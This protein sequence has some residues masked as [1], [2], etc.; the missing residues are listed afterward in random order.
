MKKKI[1]LYILSFFFITFLIPVKSFTKSTSIYKNIHPKYIFYVV[2][3]GDTLYRIAKNYNV[4]IKA[5]KKVN[6]LSCN[7]IY[8]G[9]VLKIPINSKNS[10]FR[11]SSLR[12]IKAQIIYYTVK[13]GDTLYNISKKYGVSI[14]ELKRLNNL[15]SS[16]IKI[17]QR[18]KIK[19]Y[20][21]YQGFQNQSKEKKVILY[22]VKEGE[23]LYV[24]SLKYNVPIESLKRINNIKD[25]V[26]F[27]GQKIKIPSNTFEKKPFILKNSIF[28]FQQK[29]K[30]L[31]SQKFSINFLS[32]SVL[33]KKDE[34]LL[35]KKFLKISRQYKYYRYRLGGNGN[36]YLDCSMFVKLVYKKLGIELPRTS[37]EQFRVGI[38][39]EKDELIP[40]DL[41]F[42]SRYRNKRRISHVGIYIGD[43]KFIHFSSSRKGLAIDSLNE[44]YF[45]SR[46]VGAKRILNGEI[47]EYFYQIRENQTS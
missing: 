6:N 33:D 31:L 36:G 19:V 5:L 8:I 40:G 41:L 4:S 34:N 15:K 47:L 22:K 43:N 3:K 17:G 26:I 38:K 1:F 37:R 27:V 14:K 11:L 12:N 23:T 30:E 7:I 39:V 29:S 25:N 10:F 18:I 28:Y 9:Q 42:F 20:K 35:K 46:F 45:K 44:A 16:K 21:P 2:K 13:K 32:K 24:I